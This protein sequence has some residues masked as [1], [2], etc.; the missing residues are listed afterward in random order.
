MHSCENHI[1]LSAKKS[2]F[3]ILHV[4]LTFVSMKESRILIF[5]IAFNILK[6]G[7]FLEVYNTNL[8][9]HTYIVGK[10]RLSV[11]CQIIMDIFFYTMSIL[12]K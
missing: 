3:A 8:V 12:S 7:C 6:L 4:S 11:V 2:N 1:F 10:W 9:S 5:N